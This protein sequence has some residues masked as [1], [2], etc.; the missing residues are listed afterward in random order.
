M[1]FRSHPCGWFSINRI[2]VVVF[3]LLSKIEFSCCSE[4]RKTRGDS[5][6]DGSGTLTLKDGIVVKGENKNGV[7]DGKWS[8]TTPGGTKKEWEMKDGVPEEVSPA[9]K[10]M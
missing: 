10:E 1:G 3:I 2:S 8:Y 7:P 5:Q 6:L 4:G 9:L